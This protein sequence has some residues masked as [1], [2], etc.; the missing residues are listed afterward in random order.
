V[1]YSVKWS[2]EAV[3]DLESIAEYIA[4]DSEFY[5]RAVVSKILAVSRLIPEQPLVGRVS[6]R[7]AKRKYGNVS[8]IVIGLCTRFKVTRSRLWRSFMG[9]GCL[10]FQAGSGEMYDY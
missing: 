5:A 8:F 6:L 4:R 10:M 7:F 1:D 2:P 3:E 9:K